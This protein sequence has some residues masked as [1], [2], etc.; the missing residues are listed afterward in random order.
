MTRRITLVLG[1][2]GVRGIAH[3]GVLRAIQEL[4]LEVGRVVGTSIGG[5]VGAAFAAGTTWQELA[6]RVGS[7]TKE[8]IVEVNRWALLINGIRQSSVFRD[9]RLRNYIEQIV[10]VDDWAELRVPLAVNA[11]DLKTGRMIWFGVDGRTDIPLR[12][13]IYASSALPL[14]YPPARFDNGYM[15]DGG[16]L[17]PLPINRAAEL[18]SDPVVAVELEADETADPEAVLEKGLVGMHHRVLN[19]IRAAIRR[20]ELEDWS[21][22]P[23]HPIRPPLSGYSTWD[24]EHNALFMEAGYRAALEV[25]A[26][27]FPSSAAGEGEELEG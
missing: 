12:D 20:T 4:D 15:V 17:D 21:G 2:G 6:E 7:F 3:V 16:I 18:S 22:P 10:P 25:L 24:F 1:G 9:L 14:Y 11:V 13:A 27:A 5:M 8:D 23:L 26:E 19:I